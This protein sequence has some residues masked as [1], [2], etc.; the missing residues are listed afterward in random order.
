MMHIC[1]I[2]NKKTIY[3]KNAVL[4]LSMFL[5]VVWSFNGISQVKTPAP[6]PLCSV[7]QNVGLSEVTIEYSRPGKK[8]RIIFGGL[9]PYGEMWRTGAN[10]STDIT[11]S[12]DVKFG[13]V[14]VKAG[15]YALYTIPNKEKWTVILHTNTEI[16]GTGGDEYDPAGEVAR[17]DVLAQAYPTSVESFTINVHNISSD[18]GD[19]V[20]LWDKTMIA[21]PFTF[22]TDKMVVS[23]IEKTMAGPSA[24]DYYSAARYYYDTDKDLKTAHQWVTKATDMRDDAYWMFRY[25]SMIEAKMGEYKMAIASAQKSMELAEKAG[26]KQYVKFNQDA[27]KE[28]SMK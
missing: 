2:L 6:S 10:G 8:D 23:S 18:G 22:E 9:V 13:S 28:W 26:N 5:F 21:V 11:F 27:I 19:L 16:W 17:F 7:T 3:M 12:D 14:A 4:I 20:V 25:K 1:I 15:K 24:N